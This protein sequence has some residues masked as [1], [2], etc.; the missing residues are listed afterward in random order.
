MC[1]Y[2]FIAPID[3]AVCLQVREKVRNVPD[4]L[5]LRRLREAWERHTLNMRKIKDILMYMVRALSDRSR[6]CVR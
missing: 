3:R 4:E 2:T 6:N 5:L 1:S